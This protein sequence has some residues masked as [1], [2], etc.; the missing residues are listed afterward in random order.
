MCMARY[1]A[2]AIFIHVCSAMGLLAYQR[3]DIYIYI[4][5]YTY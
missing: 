2:V 1:F 5:A 4:H 3:Y